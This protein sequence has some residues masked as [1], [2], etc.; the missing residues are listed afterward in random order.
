MLISIP[1]ASRERERM[2]VS[3][4]ASPVVSLASHDIP[5]ADNEFRLVV[6]KE[7]GNDRPVSLTDALVSTAE[8]ILNPNVFRCMDIPV[9]LCMPVSS[10]SAE[11]SFSTMRRLKTYL[12]ST[13]W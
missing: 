6:G 5:A 1:N 2:N 9:L 4:R 12:R 10:A 3:A 8:P 11:R 7:G 13:I